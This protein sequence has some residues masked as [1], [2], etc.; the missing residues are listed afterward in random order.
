MFSLL[1]LSFMGPLSVHYVSP[2]RNHRSI[3]TKFSAAQSYCI[4]HSHILLLVCA[5]QQGFSSS[6]SVLTDTEREQIVAASKSEKAI[7]VGNRFFEDPYELKTGKPVDAAKG[8]EDRMRVDQEVLYARIAKGVD[9]IEEEARIFEDKSP[10]DNAELHNMVKYVI[11]EKTSE[12]EYQNGIRDQGRGS[13]RPSHFVSHANAQEAGLKESEVFALRIYTTS[14]FKNLNDPLRDDNRCARRESVPLP[15][16]S[17]LI[18]KAIRK[19]RTVRTRAE[20]KNVVLWRGLRNVRMSKEFM[21]QGGTELAFMST[22]MDLRVAVRY[23]LS[24]ESL[25]LK[26]VAP[27][28]MSIGAELK[29]LSAFPGEDEVLFPPLTFLQPTGRTDRVDTVDCNNN[30]VTFTVVEVTPYF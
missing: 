15:A 11:N 24:K 21:Q 4:S 12:K 25:L 9:G 26:I 13:L 2:D 8:L 30:P 7:G 10:E 17:Y 20:Q 5:W 19:M 18:D 3:S 29:W 6:E 22:T 28:F 14:A 23:S 1:F 16:L 27:N